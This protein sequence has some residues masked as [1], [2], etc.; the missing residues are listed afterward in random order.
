MKATLADYRYR[1]PCLRL[2]P[3]TGS[4]IYLTDHPRDLVIGGHTPE[5][6]RY[7]FTGYD[8]QAGFSPASIDIEGIASASGVTR[9]AVG[10]GL[11]TGPGLARVRHLLGITSRGPGAGHHRRFRQATLFR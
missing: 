9:A 10:S 11:L 2:V 8:A 6:F 3:V 5:H 4:P 1:T 7:E